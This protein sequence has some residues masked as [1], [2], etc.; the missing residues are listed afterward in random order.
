MTKKE[1]NEPLEETIPNEETPVEEIPNEQA[2]RIAALEQDLEEAKDRFLRLMAEYDNFRKR[3]TKERES[4]YENAKSETIER[5][6]P[7]Y[8]NLERASVQGSTDEVLHKGIEMIRTQFKEALQSLGVTEIAA[9]GCPFDPAKHNAVQH[10]DQDDAP[11]NTVVE[12]FQKGF[13]LN[14]K[15]IR[16]AVVVV[17]N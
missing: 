15:V 5:L 4:Y 3:T 17:A 16:Y 12:V 1:K 10:V 7:V 13:E 11:E 6:L 2:E 9:E 8:D 14:G